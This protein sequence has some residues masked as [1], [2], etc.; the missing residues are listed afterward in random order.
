MADLPQTEER[1]EAQEHFRSILA[2]LG[3]DVTREGLLDTPKRYI[4]FMEEFLSK[5][6]FSFTTFENEGTDEMI[7]QK[8]IHFFSLCEH[9]TAPFFGTA[10]VA[11]IPGTRIVGLSKLARTVHHYANRFQNQERITQ[12]I[13][14]RLEKELAPKGVAVTMEATHLCMEMRGVKTHGTSTVTTKLTGVFLDEH[15]TRKE[16][17]DTIAR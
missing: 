5:D 1:K 3:E 9:H 15:D 10:H 6:E 11:Y 7:V 14:D 16:F 12:Q 2:Y 17:F 4:K 8:D 13:A